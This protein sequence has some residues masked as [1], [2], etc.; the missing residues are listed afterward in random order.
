MM[1][2][3]F[4][5]NRTPSYGIRAAYYK[6]IGGYINFRSNFKRGNSDYGCLSDGTIGNSSFIW[7]TGNEKTS[8][9]NISAGVI[10]QTGW[11]S[12]YAGAGYGTNTLTWE[13]VGG[14]WA[15]VDDFSYKGAAIDAGAVFTINNFAISAG[16]TSI[17]F[18]WGEFSLGF[19]V[20]F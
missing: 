11:L 1:L 20:R 15:K 3:D 14:K 12:L 10:S 16:I 6:K 18:D 5:A 17:A 2:A 8:R 9:T 19:G 7:T 13:D 4:G